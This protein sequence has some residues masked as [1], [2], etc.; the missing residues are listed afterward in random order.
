[1][2][3]SDAARELGRVRSAR[4]AAAARQNGKLGGR[5]RKNAVQVPSAVLI[6]QPKG[7]TSEQK[8]QE[9]I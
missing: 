6:Q 3:T 5:P 1:M 8:Q 7:K 2:S 9:K 4:K